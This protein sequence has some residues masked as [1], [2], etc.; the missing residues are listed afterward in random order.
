MENRKITIEGVVQGVGSR[1]FIHN[2]AISLDL[3]GFVLNSSQGVL[4]EVESTNSEMLDRFLERIRREL[5][6]LAHIE[7]LEVSPSEPRGYEEFTIRES[8]DEAGH[9]VLISPDIV[10]CADC[11]HEIKDPADHRFGYPFINCTNC[12]AP[13]YHHTG[14][15]VRSPQEDHGRLPHVRDMQAGLR[16]PHGSAFS[17]PA[18]SLSSMQ[19]SFAAAAVCEIT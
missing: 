9:Y 16:G 6:P 3:K 12:K 17:C 15:P 5:P 19:T 13:L 2:L 4:I 1:P 11:L 7:H 18:H 14:H 8:L 10:T